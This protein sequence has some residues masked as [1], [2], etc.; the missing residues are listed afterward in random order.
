VEAASQATD[1]T[2]RWILG[3]LLL[4]GP[5]VL[6]ARTLWGPRTPEPEFQRPTAMDLVVVT[7]GVWPDAQVLPDGPAWRALLRR[8]QR[9]GPIWATSDHPPGAAASLWTGRFA[10]G[11]GVRGPGDR[12]APGSWTLAEAARQSGW[13]T[14]VFSSA[15]LASAAGITGFETV[16]EDTSLDAGGLAARARAFL[17]AERHRRVLLW[18]HLDD[19]GPGGAQAETLLGGVRGALEE[20]G[21]R[22]DTLLAVTALAGAAGPLAEAGLRVPYAGEL[23]GALNAGRSSPAVLSHVDATA[24]WRVLMRLPQPSRLANQAGLQGREQSFWGALRGSP[25]QEWVWLDGAF[26]EVLRE[27]GLRVHQ[28]GPE[29]RAPRERPLRVGRC[30]QDVAAGI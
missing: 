19:P 11:H 4:A 12:L 28:G 3:V 15:A 16:E 6:A 29:A 24:L 27:P 26:G 10:P 5:L 14:G 25:G 13:R 1:R 18:L 20:S 22:H 2:W 7:F 9:I 17:M 21:R 8:G 23:P 30:L